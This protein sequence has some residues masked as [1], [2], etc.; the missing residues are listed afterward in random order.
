[1]KIERHPGPFT[2]PDQELA[3]ACAM[4]VIPWYGDFDEA[5]HKR[6]MENGIWND[7]ISVQTALAVIHTL[8]ING[9]LIEPAS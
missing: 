7:H 2:G 5:T 3:A 1:M 4:E 9:R 8:R 6:A